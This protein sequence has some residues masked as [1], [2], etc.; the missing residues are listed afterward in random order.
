MT[1]YEIDSALMALVN[2]E[3]EIDDYEAFEQL[4]LARNDKI[5]GVALWVKNLTAEAKA[6]CEEEKALAARRASAENKV[7]RLKGYLARALNGDKFATSKVQISYR[8]STAVKTPNEE[9]AIAWLMMN[10]RN[11]LLTYTDPKL[12]R[13]AIKAAIKDGQAL[14][15]MFELETRQNLQI[16]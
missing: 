12:N 7:E 6:I 14:D 16:K 3:G 4:A 13:T 9:T 1:L 5:E 15:G 11:D 2:E 10:K 8:S